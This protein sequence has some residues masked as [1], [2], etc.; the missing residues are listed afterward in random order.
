MRFNLWLSLRI[1]FVRLARSVHL[2]FNRIQPLRQR[3]GAY[4]RTFAR[5]RLALSDTES[6]IF[7]TR[8]ILVTNTLA[9]HDPARTTLHSANA[10]MI[11]R[12]VLP[13][14]VQISCYPWAP[15]LRVISK[16]LQARP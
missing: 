11:A 2:F 9:F 16:A 7:T 5:K 15:P 8:A 14:W 10:P 13:P 3:S 1:H 6:R 12:A 4:N